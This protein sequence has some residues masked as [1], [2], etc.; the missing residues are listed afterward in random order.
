MTIAQ[1]HFVI[2]SGEDASSPTRCFSGFAPTSHNISNDQ[3]LDRSL[4]GSRDG[5]GNR[6]MLHEQEVQ[7]TEAGERVY[8]GLTESQMWG[9]SQEEANDAWGVASVASRERSFQELRDMLQG[10]FC[11]VVERPVN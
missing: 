4:K 5:G 1:G 3:S 6:N 2:E 7:A 10:P 9:F 8:V 11:L